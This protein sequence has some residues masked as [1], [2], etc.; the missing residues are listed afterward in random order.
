M[1]KKKKSIKK[2]AVETDDFEAELAAASGDKPEKEAPVVEEV[3][4]GDMIK[5]TGIWQ[6][7]RQGCGQ[8]E[9]ALAPI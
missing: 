4:E 9:P 2:K 1:K 3:Q 7:V 8:L 6:Y 5:G